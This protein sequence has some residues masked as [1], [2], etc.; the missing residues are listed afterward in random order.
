MS[1]FTYTLG[2]CRLGGWLVSFKMSCKQHDGHVGTLDPWKF[3]AKTAAIY[4]SSAVTVHMIPL[5]STPESFLLNDIYNR[6]VCIEHISIDII[7]LWLQYAD[8]S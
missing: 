2:F 8:E 1:T 4:N 6:I 7:L 3:W 5:C